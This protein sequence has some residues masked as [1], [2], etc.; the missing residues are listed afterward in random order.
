V[1]SEIEVRKGHAVAKDEANQ[2]PVRTGGHRAEAR[3]LQGTV[4]AA[5]ESVR[6][7]TRL[8]AVCVGLR[9]DTENGV[10]TNSCLAHTVSA[11]GYR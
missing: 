7:L 3:G 8:D 9:R 2:L 6:L 10:C 1:L 11:A 4:R 5:S